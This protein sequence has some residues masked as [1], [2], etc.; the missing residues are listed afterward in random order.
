MV[1]AFQR[2]DEHTVLNGFLQNTL[3]LRI[4]RT[5]IARKL[6]HSSY[7]NLA[8][9]N[10]YGDDGNRNECQHAVHR[11][12]IAERSNEKCYDRE[13]AGDDFGKEIHH[14]IDVELQP[15]EHIA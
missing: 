6:A 13:C 14:V 3:Y 12:Q 8:Q 5:N 7:I 11:E 15:I 1:V 4:T 10:E 9:A 2:L